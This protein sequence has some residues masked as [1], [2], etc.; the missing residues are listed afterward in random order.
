MK[1][2]LLTVLVVLGVH[3]CSA[4]IGVF[5]SSQQDQF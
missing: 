3:L 1:F 5:L 2:L 4:T